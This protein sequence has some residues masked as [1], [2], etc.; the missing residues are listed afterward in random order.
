MSGP[1]SAAG[2]SALAWALS[3]SERSRQN[4]SYTLIFSLMFQ[5]TGEC[6]SM[7][8]TADWVEWEP[9]A[10]SSL[11]GSTIVDLLLKMGASIGTIITC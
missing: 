9:V 11:D 2:L 7:V 6:C 3:S 5:Q 10:W 8:E 4:T 1:R